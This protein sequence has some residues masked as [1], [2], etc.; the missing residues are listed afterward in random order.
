MLHLTAKGKRDFIGTRVSKSRM[1]ETAAPGRH[2]SES[3][4]VV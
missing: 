4:V 3:E 2:P 1:S